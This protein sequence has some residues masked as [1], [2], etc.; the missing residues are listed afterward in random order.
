[1]TWSSSKA[2]AADLGAA[3]RRRRDYLDLS[4]EHVAHE[5]GLSVRHYAK[6]EAGQTNATLE[7]LLNVA[8]VLGIGFLEMVQ[9]AAGPKRKPRSRKR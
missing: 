7:T 9:L 8:L 3:I 4:Q 1:V 6:V 5:A 2:L